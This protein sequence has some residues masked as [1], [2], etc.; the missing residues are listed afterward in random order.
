M[1]LV[2]CLQHWHGLNAEEKKAIHN[3]RGPDDYL[4][5]SVICGI[6]DETLKCIYSSLGRVKPEFGK[7]YDE[8]Q[9][10]W[11]ED[12]EHYWGENHRR[13]Y[14]GD[15]EFIEDFMS[16]H[17][18]EKFRLYYASFYPERFDMKPDDAVKLFLSEVCLVTEG[19]HGKDFPVV[20]EVA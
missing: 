6:T 1:E 12:N 7:V 2:R 14:T 20:G 13:P 8:E 16:Y 4:V 17:I 11:I 15:P 19:R 9:N 3:V 10:S 18:C 5:I